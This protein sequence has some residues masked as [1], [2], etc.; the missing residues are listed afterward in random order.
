LY[1]KIIEGLRE[2]Y[3]ELNLHKLNVLKTIY[4]LEIKQRKEGLWSHLVEHD[5]LEKLD[6]SISEFL[7]SKILNS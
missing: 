1:S 4:H 5:Q 3:P 2:T 7:E 6:A